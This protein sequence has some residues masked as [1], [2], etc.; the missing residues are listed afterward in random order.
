MCLF[1]SVMLCSLRISGRISGRP[2]PRAA[3]CFRPVSARMVQR[4]L[5]GGFSPT[6]R[7]Q[8]SSTWSIAVATTM[9]RACEKG[10]LSWNQTLSPSLPEDQTVTLQVCEGSAYLPWNLIWKMNASLLEL[11]ERPPSIIT[12]SAKATFNK[13]LHKLRQCGVHGA[14]MWLTSKV[15]Q[16]LA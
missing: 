2:T 12:S 1:F 14:S 11:S 7:G 3:E 9:R 4:R 16:S 10:R 15:C 5:N 8:A 6:S 13:H